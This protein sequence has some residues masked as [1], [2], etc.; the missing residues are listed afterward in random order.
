MR[1]VLIACSRTIGGMSV[2]IY[3]L[4][5]YFGSVF[6]LNFRPAGDA[7]TVLNELYGGEGLMLCPRPDVTQK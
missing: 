7:Y 3:K 6:I 5:Y 1:Q 4:F 2:I